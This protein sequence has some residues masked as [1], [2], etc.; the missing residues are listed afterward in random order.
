M[1]YEVITKFRQ[2]QMVTLILM[3]TNNVIAKIL[4]QHP[5]DPLSLPI[6]LRVK[7]NITVP[8]HFGKHV[9]KSIETFSNGP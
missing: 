4:I 1:F 2:T 8:F 3:I 6:G 7:N 9:I 5:I